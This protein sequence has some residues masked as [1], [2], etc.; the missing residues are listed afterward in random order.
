MPAAYEIAAAMGGF[1]F[2]FCDSRKFHFGE[3]KISPW[4]RHD[5][6]KTNR[7]SSQTARLTNKGLSF[8][9]TLDGKSADFDF[10]AISLYSLTFSTKGFLE[11]YHNNDYCMLFPDEK[12]RCVI[13]WT[14]AAEEIHNLYDKRWQD[15]CADAYEKEEIYP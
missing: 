13:K 5:F 11:F 14:L 1:N 9:G 8:S 12:D 15:A 7:A 4:Q 2:I 3:G 6:I 10:P